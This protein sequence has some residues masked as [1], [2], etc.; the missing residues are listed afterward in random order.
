G[1]QQRRPQR[2]GE[3][4]EQERDAT[5]GQ[6]R[7]GRQGVGAVPVD[8]L[9][10]SADAAPPAVASSP[11]AGAAVAVAGSTGTRIVRSAVTGSSA[12]AVTNRG[13]PCGGKTRPIVPAS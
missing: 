13:E 3:D 1:A 4:Q 2:E 11:V 9:A 10:A 6:R 8:V 7:H 5:V 12:S